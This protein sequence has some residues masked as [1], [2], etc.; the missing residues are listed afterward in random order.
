MASRQRKETNK[1][2][3]KQVAFTR[4]LLIVAVFVLWIGGISARLVHLQVNQ[5]EWLLARAEGM[6]TVVKRTRMPRGTIY[7]RNGRVLAMS[8]NVKTLYANPM[9][10][11]DLPSAARTIAKVITGSNPI[12]LLKQLKEAKSAERK[13]LPLAKNLDEIAV[14]RINLALESPDV[15]KADS[16]RFA[17]LYWREGQMRSYP[18]ETLA[19][20]V[21]GFSN[22][23]GVGQAGIEQSQNTNL[24]G[25]VIKKTSERDRLG[26]I[27]DETVSEKEAPK[28]IVLTIDSD[29]QFQAQEALEKAVRES[30]AKSGMVIVTD[31]RT[32]EILALANY[33]TFNPNNLS[34]INKDNLTN[35]VIQ[36][37]YSPGS[38]FKL[39]TYGSALEN[40]LITPDG[41]IDAG[42]GTIEVA[43]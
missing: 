43:K 17:G 38:V 42:N 6:R 12:Q 32:G 2:S 34:E 13:F 40:K 1:K 36:S 41:M 14:Q 33:P 10:I 9:E 21:I 27:Y 7:D 4:F 16:P 18:H 39:V 15:K 3:L 23:D 35:R 11:A 25:E 5:H 22:A 24:Y 37:V 26:R 19:A 30:G 28:D 8:V 29:I 20:H 31:H